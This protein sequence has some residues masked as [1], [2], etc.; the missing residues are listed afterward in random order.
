MKFV[1]TNKKNCNNKAT[2]I[3]HKGFR[4]LHGTPVNDIAL[5]ILPDS[6]KVSK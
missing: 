6:K 2:V 1:K 3:R 5:V 4:I